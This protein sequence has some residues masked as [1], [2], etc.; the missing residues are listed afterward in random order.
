V[1]GGQALSG[2]SA[3]LAACFAAALP[4]LWNTVAA[5]LAGTA[6][7]F[8]L[9][10]V[11]RRSRA[12]RIAA[13]ALPALF[14]AS[15]AAAQQVPPVS[16][17][18][19]V[20][21]TSVPEEEVDLGSAVTVITRQEIE[22]REK[23]SVL[24]L[25]RTVA[26]LDVVQSGPPGSVTSLFTRGT[27]STQ[28]LVLVDGVRMNSPFF[29]GYDWSAMTTENIE[30]IE[31]VRGPFSA[32]YGS[33][34]IGGVVQIF[35]RTAGTGVAGRVTGEAG[36]QGQGQTSAFVSGGEGMFFGSGS[37]RYNAFDGDR[38][39]TDWR[40]RAAPRAWRPGCRT[41]AASRSRGDSW[42]ARSATPARSAFP[43]RRAASSGRS[44]SRCP[45]LSLSPT[46]TIWTCSWRASPPSR[47]TATPTAASSRRPTRGPCRRASRT[48]RASGRTP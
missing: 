5:D 47:S 18:V 15:S 6:I 19:V 7:L 38:P 22:R 24:E 43:A 21:A 42:T 3:G 44:A 2:T 8:G 41:R 32:L 4:F 11:V 17:G 30:R 10:S 20:T 13:A 45:G 26:G 28:T 1:G 33:D 34:A 39:N 46:R 12:W 29:A 23:S 36:N 9:D 14:L 25:L 40:Q 37:F 16:E 27:N 48:R 31:I 35:T